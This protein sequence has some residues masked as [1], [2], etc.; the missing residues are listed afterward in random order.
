MMLQMV[1]PPPK[2][3]VKKLLPEVK[4]SKTAGYTG[5]FII[6]RSGEGTVSIKNDDALEILLSNCEDAY[7]FPPYNDLKEFLY[8]YD[9]VDLRKREQSIIRQAFGG[10]PAT[11]IRSKNLDW[12]CL[13]PTFINEQSRQ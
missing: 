6:E 10:L 2:Y 5:M 3:F 7:G 9:G 13:I 4:L 12:W 8:N 11:M 1:V